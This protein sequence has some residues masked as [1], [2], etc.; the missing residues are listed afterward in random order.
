MNLSISSIV[1][2]LNSITSRVANTATNIASGN[3]GDTTSDL[4]SLSESTLQ[5]QAGITALKKEEQLAKDTLN[6]VT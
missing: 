1:S 5:F 2:G 6:I 4:V 3:S